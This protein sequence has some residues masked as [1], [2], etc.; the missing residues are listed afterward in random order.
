MNRINRDILK[1][2]FYKRNINKIIN[3]L[4]FHLNIL[5]IKTKNII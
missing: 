2:I 4:Y 3:I 1:F 5:Y